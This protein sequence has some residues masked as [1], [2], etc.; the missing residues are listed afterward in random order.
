MRQSTFDN[1]LR[2]KY[3]ADMFRQENIYL[4]EKN[5]ALEAEIILIR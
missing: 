3:E 2:L 5:E 1:I 4:L